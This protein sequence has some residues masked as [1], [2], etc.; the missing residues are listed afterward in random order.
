METTD[1]SSR[2]FFEA[3]N[4]ILA[5]PLLSNSNVYKMFVRLECLVIKNCIAPTFS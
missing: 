1:Q 4:A 5:T 2:Q 3:F